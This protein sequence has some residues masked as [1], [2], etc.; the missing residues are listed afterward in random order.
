M[1]DSTSRSDILMDHVQDAIYVCDAD[2]HEFRRRPRT[3]ANAEEH[4]YLD[5][6]FDARMF[7]CESTPGGIRG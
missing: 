4:N 2:V 3:L 1:D 7:N 5:H 6:H